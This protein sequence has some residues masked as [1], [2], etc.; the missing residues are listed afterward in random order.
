MLS[1]LS[2]N[3]I[4]YLINLHCTFCVCLLF[5]AFK[6]G[7]RSTNCNAVVSYHIMVF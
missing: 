2:C 3:D 7:Q 5:D 6:V 1:L 4:Y